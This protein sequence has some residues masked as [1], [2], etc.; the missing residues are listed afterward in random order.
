MT[1]CSAAA[2]TTAIGHF[3][4]TFSPIIFLFFGGALSL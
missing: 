3:L 1:A 2:F 4:L